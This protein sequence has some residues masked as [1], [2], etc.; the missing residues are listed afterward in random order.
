MLGLEG[1]LVSSLQKAAV[2]AMSEANA[3]SC[4]VMTAVGSLSEVRLRC[5]NAERDNSNDDGNKSDSKTT[6]DIREWKE[7]FE[8][9][10]L[11]GTFC[12]DGKHLHMC[13]GNANGETFGGHV[14]SGTIFTTLE[15]VLGT[16]EGVRFERKHDETTGYR[17]LVVGQEEESQPRNNAK[18]SRTD[19]NT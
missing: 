8:V 16:I 5:A 4:F 10:S 9:L 12:Q 18:R 19:D 3:S 13:I 1:D 14:M 6:N 15:V 2:E 17:E 11:V 7:R